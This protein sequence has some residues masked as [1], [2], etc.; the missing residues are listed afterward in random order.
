MYKRQ[1]EFK[2]SPKAKK[3]AKEKGINLRLIKGTGPNGR[4]TSQDVLQVED[5]QQANGTARGR[6]H[7]EC[8]IVPMTKVGKV[9][10]RK[11]QQSN[12]TIPHF[13]VSVDVD[14]TTANTFRQ[15]LDSDDGHQ[16]SK[17]LTITDMIVRA[18]TIALKKYPQLNSSVKDDET[19][20]IWDDI[21]IGIA[22]AIESGLV[23]PV[24][25]KAGE[26]S[27]NEI[28][29]ESR[30]INSLARVGKQASLVPA[31]FTVSNLGMFNVDNFI[32]IINPPEAAILAVSSIKKKV[33]AI[34][35]SEIGIRDIMKMTLS[36]DHRITD[37][38]VA[39]QFI[40]EIKSLLEQPDLLM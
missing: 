23:V 17:E 35:D 18:C 22:T 7:E 3:L 4:I 25:E 38:L 34:G 2:V 19:I 1:A 13:Y 16:K 36:V 14:M 31:R 15:D 30:R 5:D 27:L 33:I 8:Q 24:I 32:A 39:T 20:I 10:A 9:T 12:S 29:N 6:T 21:N 37:G 11:M 28:T 40:N 26:L